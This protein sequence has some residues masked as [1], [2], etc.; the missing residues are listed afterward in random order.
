MSMLGDLLQSGN[1]DSILGAFGKKGQKWT[2][3]LSWVTGGKW[4]DWTSTDI[5][6]ASNQVLSKVMQPF[7]KV[8]KTINPVR[9]YVPGVDKFSDVVADKPASAIGTVVGGIFAAPA[10]GG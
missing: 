7:E 5:P 9:R 8:D 10:I 4:A 2:D 1:H 6:R 3:P